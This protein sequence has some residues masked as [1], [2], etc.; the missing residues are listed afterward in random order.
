MTQKLFSFIAVV[1]L[2]QGGI[3]GQAD[4]QVQYTSQATGNCCQP[5]PTCCGQA[6]ESSP[7]ASTSGCGSN[8]Y[9]MQFGPPVA[10]Y[11]AYANYGG[12][13]SSTRSRWSN[14]GS[15][16]GGSAW[17]TMG[18]YADQGY[19][20]ASP[21]QY[22]TTGFSSYGGYVSDG[23][24]GCRRKLL[25]FYGGSSYSGWGCR[26]S[27]CSPWTEGNWG[28]PGVIQY[29]CGRPRRVACGVQPGVAACQPALSFAC[30]PTC[31]SPVPTCCSS[32]PAM[33]APSESSTMQ[34]MNSLLLPTPASPTPISPAPAAST[35]VVPSPVAPAPVPVPAAPTPAQPTPPAAPQPNP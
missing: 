26:T 19:G 14:C 33:A 25:S 11:V 22:A 23:C 1:T 34:P 32:S 7:C 3:I 29:G 28:H 5:M 20:Y 30:A 6:I 13:G 4:A 16:W 15:T 12:C 24:G 27:A 2:L 17:G 10:N 31:C 9:A 18:G 21:R 8:G 35:P